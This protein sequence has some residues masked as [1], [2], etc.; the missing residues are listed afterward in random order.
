MALQEHYI[1]P[2]PRIRTTDRWSR[3]RRSDGRVTQQRTGSSDDQAPGDH[4]QADRSPGVTMRK[5]SVA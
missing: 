5:R 1:R 4:W 2:I 3:Q